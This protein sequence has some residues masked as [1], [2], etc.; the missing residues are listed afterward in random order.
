MWKM[1]IL[2]DKDFFCF[3]FFLCC[4]SHP[5]V[6]TLL[7]ALGS[8]QGAA[9]QRQNFGNV[10]ATQETS[11]VCREIDF[12]GGFWSWASVICYSFKRLCITL[13][14]FVFFLMEWNNMLLFNIFDGSQYGLLVWMSMLQSSAK[15]TP[16]FCPM[17]HEIARIF[18]NR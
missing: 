14:Y 8:S 4:S 13:Y 2:G 12:C 1:R 11:V 18:C 6:I 10:R 5:C 15:F 9:F 17:F 16:L 7:E 3:L